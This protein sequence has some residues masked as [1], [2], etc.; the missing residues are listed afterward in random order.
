M[1]ATEITE[2]NDLA[3]KIGNQI[4]CLETNLATFENR[5][6]NQIVAEHR[7]LLREISSGIEALKELKHELTEL[8]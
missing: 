4:F 1:T 8:S 2:V 7:H 6:S 5:L 3:E